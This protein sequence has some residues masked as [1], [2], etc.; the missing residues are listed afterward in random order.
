MIYRATNQSRAL[1]ERLNDRVQ[2]AG[3]GHAVGIDEGEQFT[4]GVASA[5]IPSLAR[6]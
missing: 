5:E 2:P 4:L 1:V 3:P 6:Q